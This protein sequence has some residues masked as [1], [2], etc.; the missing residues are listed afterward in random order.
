MTQAD[1]IVKP[2]YEKN[3]W[4]RTPTPTRK[5]SLPSYVGVLFYLFYFLCR[6]PDNSGGITDDYG[7]IR[8]VFCYDGT[9][10]DYDVIS[11]VH[12]RKDDAVTAEPDI[13]TDGDGLTAYIICYPGFGIHWMT[14][15][16]E[17]G[18][19]SHQ[20][21]ITMVI[22]AASSM[23]HWKLAKKFLRHGY[24]NHNRSEMVVW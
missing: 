3:K 4:K 8:N 23:T 18:L 7:V 19:W 5:I 6:I 22:G 17:T 20:T 15:G 10:T 13:V 24:E 2:W 21:V 14:D 1:L 9:C 16:V 11:D 12:T